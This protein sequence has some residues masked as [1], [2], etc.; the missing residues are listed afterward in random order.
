MVLPR[1]RVPC[2]AVSDT[3]E[4]PEQRGDNDILACF[5]TMVYERESHLYCIYLEKGVI[6]TSSG[7]HFRAAVWYY[8][9][10]RRVTRAPCSKPENPNQ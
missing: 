2:S 7:V 1:E 4:L 6:R 3:R 10:E 9:G 8:Q 5:L